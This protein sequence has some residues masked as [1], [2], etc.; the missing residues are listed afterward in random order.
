MMKMF[1]FFMVICCFSEVFS[2]IQTYPTDII[3]IENSEDFRVIDSKDNS[4]C[5]RFQALVYRNPEKCV[6]GSLRIVMKVNFRNFK[7]PIRFD[8]KVVENLGNGKIFDVV[9]PKDELKNEVFFKNIQ[10]KSDDSNYKLDNIRLKIEPAAEISADQKQVSFGRI[11]H[12]G[13]R[14]VS[15]NSPSTIIRYSVLKD[16]VCEVT[17]KNNFQLKNGDNYIPYSMNELTENGE[18]DLP[19]DRNEYIANF[20]IENSWK[21]VASGVYS[22]KITFSIKTDL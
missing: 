16:A 15:E 20:R 19:S 22:D 1:N 11:Y 14:L 5:D 4:E 17:S 2:R 10:L 7:E 12:N 9:I 21:K 3:S 18:I 8:E 13:V 6:D